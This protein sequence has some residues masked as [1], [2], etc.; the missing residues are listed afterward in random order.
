MKKREENQFHYLWKNNSAKSLAMCSLE[1]DDDE[2]LQ[3][4]GNGSKAFHFLSTKST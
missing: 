2:Q 1:E 4:V 3:L